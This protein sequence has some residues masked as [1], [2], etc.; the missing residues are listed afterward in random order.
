M[1][2]LY[3]CHC[4][5]STPSSCVPVAHSKACVCHCALHS[6][7]MVPLQ[8]V[9]GYSFGGSHPVSLEP[10]GPGSVRSRRLIQVCW[11]FSNVKYG[12]RKLPEMNKQQ[13]PTCLHSPSGISAKDSIHLIS[14][15]RACESD[16]DSFQG[17]VKA[18]QALNAK[19]PSPQAVHLSQRNER[20]FVPTP[21]WFGSITD[22]KPGLGHLPGPQPKI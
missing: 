18:A 20:R 16:A 11:S 9:P 5:K 2:G 22:S 14:L 7:A 1:A 15:C 17:S 19:P 3:L 21:R 6:V 12:E 10:P 8:G 4:L 13:R